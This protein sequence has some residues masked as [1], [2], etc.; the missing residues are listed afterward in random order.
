MELDEIALDVDTA[1][2]CGLILNELLTN[3]LKYA[4]PDDRSGSIH[5]TLQAAAEHVI[6]SVHDTGIGFPE[7]CDF[8][9][10]ESLGL[11]L[12]GMM[13]EQLG[14]TLTL[15]CE[16]GTTFTV[17]I[18]YCTRSVQEDVYARGPDSDRGR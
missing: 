5:I 14:G 7:G 1:I 3:A 15:T 9:H 4:F 12:V 17:T 13:T 2:P 16:G 10:T 8:R 11:Q 6:L 18:P